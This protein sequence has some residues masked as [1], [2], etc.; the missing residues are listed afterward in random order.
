MASSPKLNNPDLK[1]KV[2]IISG[3]TRGIGRECAIALAKCGC[4]I[5][6]AAKTTEPT[7]N[8]PGTIFSVAEEMKQLGVDALPC[9][10]DMRDAKTIEK[11]VE[12][13]VAHF[14]RIDIVINNASALWWHDIEDTPINKYDLITGINTRGSFI[15]TKLALPYMRKNKFGRVITMSPPIQTDYERYQGFTAYNISKFGMTM[16]AMGAAAEGAKNN[17]TGNSLWPATVVESQASKNF[18]LGS[19]KNWRKATILADCVLAIVGSTLNGTQNIDDELLIEEFGFTKKDLAVYRFDPNV[20]PI[21]ALAPKTQIKVSL[22]RGDVRTLS[23][24]ETR[25]SANFNESKL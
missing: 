20:E 8:L 25:T 18:K 5:V 22:K 17:I 7:K 16:V 19:T 24:D 4:N 15:L 11:C 1:G 14:G 23:K 9:K 12:D 10:V 3:S 6:I 13:T 2:A 21:R